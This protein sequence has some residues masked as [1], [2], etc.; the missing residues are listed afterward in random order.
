MLKCYEFFSLNVTHPY[1]KPV[2]IRGVSNLL[3]V[4]IAYDINAV[5]DNF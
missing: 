4:R 5:F 1:S 3:R 2:S